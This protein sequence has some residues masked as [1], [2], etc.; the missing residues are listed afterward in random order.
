MENIQQI[1]FFEI[2]LFDF[3]SFFKLSGPLWTDPLPET[4]VLEVFNFHLESAL[5]IVCVRP[6]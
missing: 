2:G 4:W 1:F 6:R 5:Y 3:T